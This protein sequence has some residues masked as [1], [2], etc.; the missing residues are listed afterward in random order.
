M[1]SASAGIQGH[2]PLPHWA[3]P[4]AWLVNNSMDQRR[5]WKAVCCSHVTLSL[6][7]CSFS[8]FL[9]KAQLPWKTMQFA[10][11]SLV[12][13]NKVLQEIETKIGT[14]IWPLVLFSTSFN[15]LFEMPIPLKCHVWWN[16]LEHCHPGFSCHVKDSVV[17]SCARM[18]ILKC[19]WRSK[20]N[21]G[22]QGSTVNENCK[23]IHLFRS[24]HNEF[25]RC[26]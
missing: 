5:E 12:F 24:F 3:S 9:E 13:Q 19:V 15:N 1:L 17:F 4:L 10:H 6:L 11:I 21:G 23:V 18:H 7:K 25:L 16:M 22:C 8:Y 26:P 20:A 14:E 2:T